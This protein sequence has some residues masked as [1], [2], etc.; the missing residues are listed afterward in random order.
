MRHLFLLIFT[1]VMLTPAAYAG[2]KQYDQNNKISSYLQN[3]LKPRLE[4]RAE[5]ER[6]SRAAE[7]KLTRDLQQWAVAGN[8]EEL[9]KL[10]KNAEQQRSHAKDI[11]GDGRV[12]LKTEVSVGEVSV[13]VNP[14]ILRQKDHLGNNLFHKAKNVQTVAALGYVVR[15][16]YP[17][18]FS[19][20]TEMKNEKNSAQ[21]TPLVAHVS[22][23]DLASFF[24]LYDNSKL[25]QNIAD[26]EALGFNNTGFAWQ[27]SAAIYRQ[28]IAKWGTNAA[29]VNVA[30]LVLAQTPSEQQTKLLRFFQTHAPYLLN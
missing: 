2:P 25:A 24:P 18:D 14:S 11:C 13:C 5:Q 27:S 21:E 9:S 20:I 15:N 29:G 19:A 3:L 17:S 12:L 28:E 23:G 16:F 6:Y 7:E 26:M 22:R 30:Q 4:A 8:T 1:V 10:A